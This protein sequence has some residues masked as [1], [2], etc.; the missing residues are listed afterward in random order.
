M[1]FSPIAAFPQS[2]DKYKVFLGKYGGKGRLL[3]KETPRRDV[4]TYRNQIKP[5]QATR[6]HRC[7]RRV[8]GC[9]RRGRAWFARSAFGTRPP[10]RP[11]HQDALAGDERFL[12]QALDRIIP[13][14]I[15]GDHPQAGRAAVHRVELVVYG[16]GVEHGCEN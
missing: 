14:V 4:S 12:A 15:A 10:R 9:C 7:P 16:E 2:G 13:P 8:A 5:L 6:P 1:S 3:K 11:Q